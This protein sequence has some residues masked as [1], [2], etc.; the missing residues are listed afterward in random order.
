MCICVLCVCVF[1]CVVCVCVEGGAGVGGDKNLVRGNFSRRGG[2]CKFSVGGGDST[3]YGK[4]R[5]ILSSY[6]ILQY[7][8]DSEAISWPHMH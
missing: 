2:M 4:P 7:P 1:V 5:Y 8:F 3:Q 6:S